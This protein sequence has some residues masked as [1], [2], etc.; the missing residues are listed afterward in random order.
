MGIFTEERKRRFGKADTCANVC[1]CARMFACMHEHAC[2]CVCARTHTWGSHVK[3]ET[4]L[5]QCC[6]KPRN[7]KDCGPPPELGKQEITPARA[8]EGSTALWIPDLRLLAS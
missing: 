7:A 5:E 1:V 3:M 4:G 8:L 6:H 2:A